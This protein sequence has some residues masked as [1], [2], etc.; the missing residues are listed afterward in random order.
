MSTGDPVVR[1]LQA[2]WWEDVLL[3]RCPDGLRVRKQLH[4]LDAPWATDVFIR[5][6]RYLRDLP[7]GLQPPFVRILD[8]C[9][10]LMCE[11][12]PLDRPLWFDMEYLEG[13]TDVRA[14]L[15]Q[16]QITPADAE[17]IQDLLIDAL[18]N[19]LYRLPGRQMSADRTIWPVVDQVLDFAV[20][21][22]DLSPYAKADAW[23]INGVRHP[24]LHRTTPAAKTD[25]A[26]RRQIDEA[27]GVRL[28]GDLFYENV[29]YRPNPP[30]IGLIDPVSVAGVSEG[31]I[32]FDRVK[33]HTW[34]T[35]ELYALRH[36]RFRAEADPGGDSP[37]FSY[38]WT[39]D[40]PVIRGLHAVDL[41]RRVLA[42]MDERIG[43]SAAAQALLTAYFNLAMV[44]NTS[45][46]QRLLRYARATELM[47]RWG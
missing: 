2:G 32:V 9:E 5:E 10:G 23:T 46:P 35:G 42:R 15:S 22:P 7:D 14:L 37:C 3:I 13:F 29:L 18:M 11:P 33:F 16:G 20:H 41:G 27:P 47:A 17:H 38:A 26:L 24:S 6:W 40:D 36:G 4:R 21:D 31:P 30:A 8:Q 45:M 43:D 39:E 44:P 19:R 25:L 1:R 28:H 34:L 12:V